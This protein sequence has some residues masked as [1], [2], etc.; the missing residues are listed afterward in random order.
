MLSS[1]FAVLLSTAPSSS[2]SSAKLS[3]AICKSNPIKSLLF[4]NKH[5]SPTLVHLRDPQFIHVASFGEDQFNFGMQP[6]PPSVVMADWIWFVR[7]G[8]LY[9]FI[10][11]ACSLSSSLSLSP[12]PLLFASSSS[13]ELSQR[14]SLLL[15][16]SFIQDDTL[17]AHC[18]RHTPSADKYSIN[19]GG[20]GRMMMDSIV[21]FFRSFLFVLFWFGG[22][23]GWIVVVEVVE[24][25]LLSLSVAAVRMLRNVEYHDEN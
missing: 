12:P 19:S 4:N 17:V 25:V 3:Q 9:C 14:S 15:F 11:S 16:P 18:G 13:E 5:T 2:S 1:T 22:G 24:A 10:G 21:T 6:P 23:L 7:F 8:K 20:S